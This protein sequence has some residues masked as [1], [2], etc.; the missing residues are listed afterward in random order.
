MTEYIFRASDPDT[1]MEKAVRELGDDAMILSVKKMGDITEVRAT[2]ESSMTNEPSW[3]DRK[4]QTWPSDAMDLGAAIRTARARRNGADPA[5]VARQ[6]AAVNPARGR[7]KGLDQDFTVG[8]VT[9]PADAP[10]SI[11]EAT[12]FEELFRQR[13]AANPDPASEALSY[14]AEPVTRQPDPIEKEPATARNTAATQAEQWASAPAP[15]AEEWDQDRTLSAQVPAAAMQ[16][17]APR[18]NESSAD[19]HRISIFDYGFPDDIAQSCAI[20]PDLHT[21]QAQQDHACRLLAARI[22]DDAEISVVHENTALFLFGPPGAGKTTVAAQLAFER[23]RTTAFH[24]RLVQVPQKGFVSCGRLQQYAT[25]L[26]STYRTL[27][28]ND[29]EDIAHNDI[30]DCDLTEPDA[31]AQALEWVTDRLHDGNV[32]PLLVLPSTWSIAAIKQ[33]TTVFAAIFPATV[34]THM[35]IGGIDIA[36]LSAMADANIKL[37]AANETRKITEGLTLVDRA[38]VEHFL[39]ES[40]ATWVV[41]DR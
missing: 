19:Q 11:L 27:S 41:G 15:S 4:R 23:L 13:L 3:D 18:L 22:T 25:V 1:A 35:D 29:D 14:G 17:S 28:F 40:L 33:Y 32:S 12:Q 30:I 34:L 5:P 16:S 26:N 20:A 39:Q 21:L 37:I 7:D 2:R 38:S 9:R 31:I 10:E 6:P 8:R 24:P 36:G